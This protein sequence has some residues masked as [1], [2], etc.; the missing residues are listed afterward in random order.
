MVNLRNADANNGL[1]SSDR[2][3]VSAAGCV[4]GHRPFFSER[5]TSKLLR[6]RVNS[7]DLAGS[8]MAIQARSSSQSAYSVGEQ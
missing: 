8:W 2:D 7:V 5:P 1:V 4:V 3:S 6:G